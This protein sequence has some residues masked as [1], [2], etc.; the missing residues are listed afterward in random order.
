MPS[1]DAHGWTGLATTV[2]TERCTD[3]ESLQASQEQHSTVAP[4]LGR[5]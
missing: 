2:E 4:G 3:T 1:E 5:V